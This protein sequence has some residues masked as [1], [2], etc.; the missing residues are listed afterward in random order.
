MKSVAL[1]IPLLFLVCVAKAQTLIPVTVNGDLSSIKAHVSA[2]VFNPD[3]ILLVQRGSPV[4]VSVFHDPAGAFG[5]AGALTIRTV[6]TVTVNGQNLFILGERTYIGRKK[7]GVAIGLGLV[8]GLVAWPLLF[9]LLKRGGEPKTY[10]NDVIL[11]VAA[12]SATLLPA[13]PY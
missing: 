12:N 5:K 9:L 1:V 2:D 8:L 3:G 6:S 11:S 7:R 10:Q 4:H 13:N